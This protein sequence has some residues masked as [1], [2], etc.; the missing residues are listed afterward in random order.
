MLKK[1][2]LPT[3]GLS[4]IIIITGVI[5]S[6]NQKLNIKLCLRKPSKSLKNN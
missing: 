3:M 1:E 6:K 2:R 4:V 5:P